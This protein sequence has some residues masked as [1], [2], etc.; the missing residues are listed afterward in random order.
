MPPEKY[1]VV[2]KSG[3]SPLENPTLLKKNRE[4]HLE[5]WKYSQ[6]E[7]SI[8]RL[9]LS[10]FLSVEEPDYPSHPLTEPV[11]WLPPRCSRRKPEDRLATNDHTVMP[12]KT[13]LFSRHG[14]R[15]RKVCFLRRYGFYRHGQWDFFKIAKTYSHIQI[16]YSWWELISRFQVTVGK[17]RTNNIEVSMKPDLI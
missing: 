7:H 9:Y 12:A 16:W 5:Y 6:L 3:D 14:L 8:F 17:C 13:W 1:L 10:V 4:H 11:R 2:H 15:T